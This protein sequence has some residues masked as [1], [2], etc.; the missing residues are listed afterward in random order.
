METIDLKDLFDYYKSKLGVVILFVVLVGILGCLYGLFI[1][2]PMYKSSTSI[3]LISEAKDNS[4][5][6]YNDVS[7]NQNL[8]ST[9]S[10]IVKSKRVLSQVINNLNLNYTYGALS[11][12][13]EV[14]S[15]TGTQIIKITVTD[16]NS[17]TAMKVANEIGKVFAKEI[18][19]LYNISNVNILDTA[20]QPSSAYNVNI[21]KQ[22]VIFLLVGLVL[23]LG[24]VFVMYYFDRSVKNASQIE[25]KLKLP[26]LAT[27]REYRG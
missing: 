12:N 19:E 10:E 22:S 8:V 18:P 6:T 26:V 27:V 20:E 9:Y 4:Q 16:E 23:G 25:N 13:I 2:K 17:K 5:L 1:Q 14:S 21:T 7:V 3:V 15:V 24:V 11:N